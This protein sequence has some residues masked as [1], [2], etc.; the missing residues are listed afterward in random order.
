MENRK[1]VG[2]PG[3][4]AL[5]K[6]RERFESFLRNGVVFSWELNMLIKSGL[7]ESIVMNTTLYSDSKNF[8]PLY[9]LLYVTI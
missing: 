3:A 6:T 8:F 2:T 7:R 9:S 1:K 5:L 4:I